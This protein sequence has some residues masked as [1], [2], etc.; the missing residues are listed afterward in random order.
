[1]SNHMELVCVEY[2]LFNYQSPRCSLW[3]VHSFFLAVRF[4]YDAPHFYLLADLYGVL[5]GNGGWWI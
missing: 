1:M 3:L 2:H 4:A 5:G